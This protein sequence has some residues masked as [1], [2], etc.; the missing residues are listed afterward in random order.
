MTAPNVYVDAELLIVAFLKATFPDA[1]VCTELPADLATQLPVIRVERIGGGDTGRS[2]DTPSLDVDCFA[3]TRTAANTLG[4]QVRTAFTKTAIGYTA[5]GATIAAAAVSTVGW[6][7]YTN[8]NV[9]CV[10]MTVAPA[11]HNHQ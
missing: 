8:L 1:R 3:A 7:P 11:L 9:R 6:R 2:I 5:L 10:G 4:G